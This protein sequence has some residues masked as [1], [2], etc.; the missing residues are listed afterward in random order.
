MNGKHVQHVQFLVLTIVFRR[1]KARKNE[2]LTNL[3]R[4]GDV[5]KAMK[6]DSSWV[7]EKTSHGGMFFSSTIRQKVICAF[8]NM[9]FC[10]GE[11][12][13]TQAELAALREA[14][15]IQMEELDP[16]YSTRQ[17]QRKIV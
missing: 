9:I 6:G 16:L 12:S 7:R 14:R 2:H 15:S 8:C 10:S 1:R 5:R 17:V 13:R 3:L 11:R 4:S